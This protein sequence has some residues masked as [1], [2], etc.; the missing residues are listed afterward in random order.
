M[1]RRSAVQVPEVPG[2]DL[3]YRPR[4]YFWAADLK[5]PLLS[6]IAGETRRQ[7]VR[8]LIEAGNPIPSGLDAAVLDEEMRQA[9]GRVHL[10]VAKSQYEGIRLCG[11]VLRALAVMLR[12]APCANSS[13]SPSTCWSPL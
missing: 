10:S 1:N 4:N 5:I 3:D 9:W 8:G 12:F 13:S 7:L 6:D 2:I 11:A